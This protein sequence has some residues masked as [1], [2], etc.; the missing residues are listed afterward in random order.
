MTQNVPT[1]VPTKPQNGSPAV[2]TKSASAATP[3]QAIAAIAEKPSTEKPKKSL[4]DKTMLSV[5]KLIEKTDHVAN[6]PQTWSAQWQLAF[7]A[8]REGLTAIYALTNA[9]PADFKAPRKT[10]GPPKI[11]AVGDTAVIQTKYLEE[12]A[13]MLESKP[14]ATVTVIKDCGKTIQAKF[15][16]GG[17][18]LVLKQHLAR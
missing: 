14:E 5:L 17:K 6:K 15:S 2:A 16:D 8:V 1:K 13:G 12:Y 4:K 9:L 18:S 3:G 7:D 10:M 11:F